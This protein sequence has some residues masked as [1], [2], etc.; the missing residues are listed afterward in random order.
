MRHFL[1]LVLC[2]S[3]SCLVW[4]ADQS[5]PT[6]IT[7]EAAQ[8]NTTPIVDGNQYTMKHFLPN[9][10]RNFVHIF[11]K[12]NYGAFLFTAIG[13]G[14]ASTADDEVHDYF[15]ERHPGRAPENVFNMI[16][17]PYVLGPAVA[18]LLLLGQH[19]ENRRFHDFSYALAQAYTL[20]YAIVTSMK[21]AVGRERPDFTSN[22]SFPS[23]HAAD[24][25]MIAAVIQNFYGNK[26]GVFGYSF[27]TLMAASRLKKDRHWFSDVVAGSAIG[28]IVGS[29]VCNHMTI[30]HNQFQ[31]TMLPLVE[32]FQHRV[33]LNVYA[34]F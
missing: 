2:F 22:Q 3:F 19:S 33:G 25:F 14:I 31:M 28:Y 32:P 8:I 4:G 5:T 27:A 9:A 26:A 11:S 18:S 12:S 1:F 15:K 21:F 20:N 23:G 13:T 24:G 29:S 34:R 17:K 16:G 6:P 10:E 30:T 7:D